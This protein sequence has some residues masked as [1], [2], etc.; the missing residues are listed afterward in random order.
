MVGLTLAI[1]WAGFCR[2]GEDATADAGSFIRRVVIVHLD[3]TRIDDLSCYGGI[4][5]T[6]NIDAVAKGGMKYTNS[7]ATYP[8]TSPS[9][10]SFLTGRFPKHTGVNDQGGKLR[11]EYVT[12]AEVLRERGFATGGFVSNLSL[13]NLKGGRLSAG[14]DQGFDVFEGVVDSRPVPE[15]E[16][17]NA[18]PESH[19]AILMARALEFVETH[20]DERFLLW[21]FNVDPHAPYVP[22]APYSEMYLAHPELGAESV[23]LHWW[24]M[25][26]QAY[27]PGRRD[28]HEYVA[29]HMAEVTMVDAWIGKLLAKLQGLP[30]KTLIVITADHGESFGD[31]D[32]WFA[33]GAN[34]R[35]PCLEVPLILACEGII[36]AGESD[37]LVANIDVVPTIL[38]ILGIPPDVTRPDG[39]SLVPT[40]EGTDPWPERMIPIRSMSWLWRGARS[41]HHS[42]HLQLD[43]RAG[44]MHEQ[45]Y[46]LRRDPK[47]T[48]N[49]AGVADDLTSAH[50]QVTVDWFSSEE[51][52]APESSLAHE[53][54]MQERLRA[55]GYID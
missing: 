24:E 47:E 13:A 10:A 44:R 22:P 21:A 12:L 26:K 15:G 32:Y 49:M 48:S 38:D 16:E 51:D 4:P 9:V 36:P 41:K 42:Y 39:R 30:G 45:L 33:H 29:R 55:L 5:D 43:F 28:S 19:C 50:R 1:G 37:A 3:T 18:V 2:A 7:I 27:V 25:H 40:F 53:P 35:H 23:R 6:P 54:E 52:A 17:K 20:K 46:D 31:N 34:T 11:Q 8:K 14:Y